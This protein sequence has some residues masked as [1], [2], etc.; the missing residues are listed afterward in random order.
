M[1]SLCEKVLCG[2]NKIKSPDDEEFVRSNLP[3]FE[4]LGFLSFNPKVGEADLKGLS[5]YDTA[6][7]TVAEAEIVDRVEKIHGGSDGEENPQRHQSE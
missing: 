2:G 3:D 1:P 5:V 7:Q 6:P 4:L